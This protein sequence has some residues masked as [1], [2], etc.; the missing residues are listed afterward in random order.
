MFKFIKTQMLSMAN[1]NESSI[2]A[3][4]HLFYL[5]RCIEVTKNLISN[6]NVFLAPKGFVKIFIQFFKEFV[7]QINL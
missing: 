3:K 2:E 6:K 4:R 5:E 1:I 7:L